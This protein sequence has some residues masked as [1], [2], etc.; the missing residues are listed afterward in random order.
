MSRRL[1]ILLA[2]AFFGF[3]SLYAQE[4]SVEAYAGAMT[5]Q[6]DL[7]D[8]IVD[9]SEIQLAYGAGFKYLMFKDI[10]VRGGVILGKIS[11]DDANSE[12]LAPRG[13]SFES[14]VT[15][16]SLAVE[17]HPLGRGR[18]DRRNDLIRSISPYVYA[19]AGYMFG[20]PTVMGLPPASED[21]NNDITSRLVVPL[22]IG[23]QATF[24]ESYYIA[25]EGGT[26]YITD[27]YLDG[28]SIE[29]NPNANDWY[30]SA[31]IKIGF[32][33]SGEPSMF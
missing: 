24:H 9:F 31:N 17:Y 28:V 32:Y 2:S 27:D 12:K 16:L 3:Y 22:G 30:L 26:R 10:A 6:G 20:T 14:K 25:L 1:Y 23:V 11:G 7:V 8:G 18:W 15:E 19:G 4:L 5:Y 33:L 13:F 29:G 21:L